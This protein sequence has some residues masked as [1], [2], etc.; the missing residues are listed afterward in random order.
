[1]K[2]KPKNIYITQYSSNKG[3]FLYI[4]VVW[5]HTA[6]VGQA[7]TP[8]VVDATEMTSYLL[9]S[10]MAIVLS[11]CSGLK[12]PVFLRE[13]SGL[14]LVG[15]SWRMQSILVIVWNARIFWLGYIMDQEVGNQKSMSQIVDYF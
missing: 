6:M 14:W 9:I 7:S 2:E 1:M 4:I 11:I 3:Q 15:L 8:F 5:L 12:W 13:T 10:R